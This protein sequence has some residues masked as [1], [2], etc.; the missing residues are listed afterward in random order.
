[1]TKKKKRKVSTSSTNHRE[2]QRRKDKTRNK[3]PKNQLKKHE[4]GMNS[5]ANFTPV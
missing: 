2:F 4:S 1:M 3:G 5:S